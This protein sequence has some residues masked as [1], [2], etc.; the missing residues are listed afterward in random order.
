MAFFRPFG[1]KAKNKGVF[2][3]PDGL[4]ITLCPDCSN[5]DQILTETYDS[6]HDVTFSQISLLEERI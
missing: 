6:N 3:F 4:I 2:Q 5:A 1:T